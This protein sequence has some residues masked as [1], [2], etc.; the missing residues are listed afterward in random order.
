MY[1]Y[2]D[3]RPSAVVVGFPTGLSQLNDTHPDDS[4]AADEMLIRLGQ[5]HLLPTDPSESFADSWLATMDVE[6]GSLLWRRFP[7]TDY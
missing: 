4:S 2:I 7:L 5:A 6:V 3:D 1:I